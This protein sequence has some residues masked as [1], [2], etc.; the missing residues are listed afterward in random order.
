[1]ATNSDKGL[2]TPRLKMMKRSQSVDRLNNN[3]Y[4]SQVMVGKGRNDLREFEYK[5]PVNANEQHKQDKERVATNQILRE[6]INTLRNFYL[7]EAKHKE[8]WSKSY[9]NLRNIRDVKQQIK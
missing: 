5:V 6:D 9:E 4:D 7:Q 3:R 8:C 2:N 1:M